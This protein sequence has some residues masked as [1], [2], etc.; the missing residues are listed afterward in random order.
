MRQGSLA[1]ESVGLSLSGAPPRSAPVQGPTA[2]RRR[3]DAGCRLVTIAEGLA[4]AC[5]ATVQD[6]I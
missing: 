2:F 6:L 4:L 5:G 3:G 1:L